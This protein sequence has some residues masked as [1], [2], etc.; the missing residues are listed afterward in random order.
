MKRLALVLGLT[1]TTALVFAAARD[2]GQK[3]GQQ[4]VYFGFLT[5]TGRV[6]GVA[7]DLAPPDAT[8][9]RLLRAYVCDGLGPPDGIAIWFK[10]SAKPEDVSNSH[11]LHITSV[12][13]HEDLRVTA[14]TDHGIYGAFTEA[15]G[16]TAHY[17]AYP[18]VGGAGIYQVTLDQNLRY[19]GT[20]TDGARLDAQA[21]SDGTT[22]GTIKPAQ[23]PAIDFTVHS[24]A[25]AS[26]AD[27]AAHGFSPEFPK[28][29]SVSQVP[30]AYVAVL[31]PYGTHWFG[32]S[33]AV[34]LGCAGGEIIGLDK[35][36]R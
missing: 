25:L 23:G 17:V 22:T 14:I 7:I 26:P 2:Q 15:S 29:A 5:G 8:G 11:P 19:T 13:G 34:L 21:T 24:L 6:G 3:R 36:A 32:R 1:L 28:F 18:A 35:K 9:Q 12:A 10:G 33:G 27:L 20:S 31:A 30:G 16:N 4:D